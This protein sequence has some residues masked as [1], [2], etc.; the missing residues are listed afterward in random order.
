MT[1]HLVDLAV[2]GA[3]PAGR[4]L[5]HRGAAAGLQVSLIDPDVDA[6]WKPTYAAWAD[7][8]P[9]WL[10]PS[11]I[12]ARSP[13]I[14]VYTP[15]RT[16]LDRP[17]VTLGTAELQQS[18]GLAGVRIHPHRADVVGE[19]SVQ[20]DDGSVVRARNVV[21]ARGLRDRDAPAQ[22]AYGIVVARSVAEPLLDGAGAILMDW[23]GAQSDSTPTFLY[24]IPLDDDRVLLEET[25]LAAAPAMSIGELRGRLTS[26]LAHLGLDI[27]ALEVFDTE[28]VR[29]P[30]VDTVRLP[31]EHGRPV[32]FGA[33]G[34][35]LHPATG[36]SVA[37]SLSAADDLIAAVATGDDPTQA[38]WPW[39]ARAVYR[40]RVRGLGALLNLPN[41]ELVGF[42]EAFFAA[43]A[44]HRRAYLSGRVHLAGTLGAMAGTA[45]HA[46]RKLAGTIIRS[47]MRSTSS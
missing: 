39:R 28:K 10:D 4:A 21:D 42:F 19:T 3:G 30:L 33:G 37:E 13:T 29:F 26:R 32:R 22:T 40:L 1:N 8:L 46:D 9:D 20:L 31:W 17:Y 34:G 36:Y 7:D 2:V 47:A 38:L 25:C 16:V 6:R 45:L 11:A 5:A 41:S 18:L 12:T 15:G 24:V 44:G 43:P 23:R 14:A 27:D 35:M